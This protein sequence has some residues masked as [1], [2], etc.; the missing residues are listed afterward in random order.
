MKILTAY[1]IGM[2]IAVSTQG[3]SVPLAQYLAPSSDPNAQAAAVPDGEEVV[4]KSGMHSGHRILE[5]RLPVLHGRRDWRLRYN[6]CLSRKEHPS[7]IEVWPREGTSGV[8]LSGTA[9]Y[10][11]GCIDVKIDG[12]SIGPYRARFRHV[13]G[14]RQAVVASWKTP[15]GEVDLTFSCARDDDRLLVTGRIKGAPPRAR[16]SIE[17]RCFPASYQKPRSRFVVTSKREAGPSTTL[18]LGREEFWVFYGDRIRDWPSDPKSFGPCALMYSPDEARRAVVRAGTYQITTE[19]HLRTGVESFHLALWAFHRQSNDVV[20]AIIREVVSGLTL[21]AAA[22]Q[23]AGAPARTLVLDGRPAATIVTPNSPHPLV[24]HAA[25]ELNEIVF[26][27]SGADLP[28]VTDS[29]APANGNRL[30]LG[31][32]PSE[33]LGREGF[34]LRTTGRDVV[35]MG[36]DGAGTL[37]GVYELL[38]RLGWRC[39]VDDPLGTVIPKCETI[40]VPGLDVTDKPDF[41]MRWIGWGA[42]S[43][44][45][46][47]NAGRRGLPSG[48]DVQPGIYHAMYR[49]F[50]PK[51]YFETHPEWFALY[52][53]RRKLHDDAKP[54][55]TAPAAALTV[56]MN[57]RRLLG[58]QPDVDLISLAFKDGASYCQCA[59]C[60][61]CD[62]TDTPR[63]QS[64]SRRALLF[65]NAVAGHL[66]KT[67]PDTKILAGAY[68]VYN[69]PPKDPDLKAHRALSL[70]L[71]HYTSYCLMHPVTDPTCP[72]NAEYRKLLAG[73]QKLIPDVYFYE[74]YWTPGWC[75]LPCP[76]V[77]VVRED[78]P[79]FHGIG[80]KGLYTQY[81]SVWNT[82]LSNY[83]AARLLWDVETDVDA[84]LDDFYHR[85]FGAAHA[86]MR[87]YFDALEH[88]IAS[89]DQ[90]RCTC[91]MCSVDPR[92]IFSDDLRAK[93]HGHLDVA[94]AATGDTIVQARLAKLGTSL[95]YADQ[96]CDYWAKVRAAQQMKPG[97]ERSRLAAGALA[98]LQGLKDDI[99]KNPLK[100]QGVAS[101]G[102]YHWRYAPRLAKRLGGHRVLHHAEVLAVLPKRWSF[103][104]DKGDVG[105]AQGWYAS[106]FDDSTWATIESGRYWEDQGYANYDGIA[107][108]R[109][110]FGLS[111]EQLVKPL[112]LAFGGVDAQTIVYVNG[113]RLMEHDGWDEPF[114]VRLPAGSARAGKNSLAVRVVD[115]SAKG[116]MYGEVKVVRP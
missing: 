111:A 16:V 107:W 4:C 108:Y 101:L 74:Y 57:M 65:Y 112:G 14:Q 42:H 43:F 78:I 23:L 92:F 99:A 106:D 17:L 35:V 98:H 13:K 8:G 50:S 94:K 95:E 90:H 79:H 5:T 24:Q 25:S 66:E 104:L 12:Q 96:Y 40:T 54:C 45:I 55:T 100:Y 82:F 31:C 18:H 1:L 116:G 30:L 47:G 110:T 32:T 77:H 26:E 15:M 86:P 115:T 103:A 87:A 73:W 97:P 38:E 83:V 84:L 80:C 33:A 75:E 81:G 29:E 41:P 11:G 62:E 19:L 58:A 53:G 3:A 34:R 68:H 59:H 102:S 85:F 63:D 56:A 6:V 89:T 105:I 113:R 2:S 46:R 67:H 60:Q 21:P 64:F 70:V 27:M 52:D 44:R 7:M 22:T 37:F 109:T 49:Y 71:C 91:G 48:F 36:G 72:K 39:Y 9:W 69:R 20:Q 88:A 10:G 51:D 114:L 93:L 76:L 28:V 61:A